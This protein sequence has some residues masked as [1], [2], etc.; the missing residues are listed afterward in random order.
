MVVYRWGGCP[1]E[2]A[3]DIAEVRSRPI[4]SS[5]ILDLLVSTGEDAKDGSGSSTPGPTPRPDS[6][7]MPGVWQGDRTV[8]SFYSGNVILAFMAGSP[9]AGF[10]FS[11]IP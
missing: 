5:P 2:I 6:L 3:G 10:W 7:L 9:L 8:L 1:R 4:R 11:R